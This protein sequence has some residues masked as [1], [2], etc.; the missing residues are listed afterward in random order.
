MK[1]I[2]FSV[3]LFATITVFG[4]FQVITIDNSTYGP[5]EPSIYINPVNTAQMVAASNINNLYVSNDSGRT[6]EIK[7]LESTH[8][9][10]GDPVIYSDEAGNFYYCHLSATINKKYPHWIDR[11]VVQ[12]SND[13]GQTFSDGCY[14]GYNGNKEQD[15]HWIVKDQH[16]MLHKNN[17]YLTWTEFDKYDSKDTN[18]HSRIQFARSVDGAQSFEKAITI[19]D[20][21]GDCLD[22]DNTLEGATPAIGP[23]GEVYVAWSGFGNIYFDKSLNGGELWGKDKVIAIQDDGWALDFNQIYRSNGLPFLVSDHSHSRFK[24]RL[25]LV[26]GESNKEQGGEIKLKYSDNGGDTWSDEITVNSNSRGDQFLPHIAIDQKDG[27][28]Y[29]VFYDRGNTASNILMDVYVAFSEDG[30][31][32]FTNKRITS[33]PFIP[34]GKEVFFGDYNGIS[35]HN[36]VVR[37]IWTAT[38]NHING[39]LIIQTALLSKESLKFKNQVLKD[40]FFVSYYRGKTE[41]TFV[42]YSTVTLNYDVRI[43]VK[44]FKYAIFGKTYKMEGVLFP[45]RESLDNTHKTILNSHTDESLITGQGKKVILKMKLKGKDT[46][47]NYKGYL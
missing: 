21:I 34:P 10:Y 36:G 47:V 24:N 37:P 1:N 2:F 27:T 5:N 46:H 8:G 11:I 18:D 41:N 14:A 44:K 19:S 38:D 23:N 45:N 43:K 15:K 26:W 7:I 9:V 31:Q 30:G 6:W 28:V 33:T 13:G 4:Q 22:D 42:I 40:T 12:K 20:T 3:L 17:I 39:K 25:Y 16:S 32:T 35:A 29:V